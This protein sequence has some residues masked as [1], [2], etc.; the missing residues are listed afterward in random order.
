MCHPRLRETGYVRNFLRDRR[1]TVAI[2]FAMVASLFLM[3]LFGIIAFG[4]QFA[5]RIAL[6]YVVAEGGRACVAALSEGECVSAATA[7]MNDALA[8]YSGL[9]TNATPAITPGTNGRI[10][11]SV[12][13]ANVGLPVLPFVPDLSNLPDVSTTFIVTDPLG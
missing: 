7:V 10:V 13:G 6:S 8:G 9:V 5:G 3:L 1:G 12:I 4:F 2:E 11:V